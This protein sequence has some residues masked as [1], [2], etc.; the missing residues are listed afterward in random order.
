MGDNTLLLDNR[1]TISASVIGT[2]SDAL[3]LHNN[4]ITTAR[5]IST[6]KGKKTFHKI[7]AKRKGNVK[8]KLSTSLHLP[9]ESSDYY[10]E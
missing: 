5:Y 4:I 9:Q 8:P 6:A 7:T 3:W 1:H 10:E 2:I